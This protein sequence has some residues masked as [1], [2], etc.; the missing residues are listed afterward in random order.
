M[1]T[2]ILSKREINC[3]QLSFAFLYFSQ[4]KQQI[5]G[6]VF[7]RN[8]SI[9]WQTFPKQFQNQKVNINQWDDIVFKDRE[10]NGLIMC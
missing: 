7:S 1:E 9:K 2:K 10:N 6:L 3:R 8:K 4:L 5:P